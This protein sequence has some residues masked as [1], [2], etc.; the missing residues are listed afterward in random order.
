MLKDGN[1]D[2]Q[3]KKKPARRKVIEEE[4]KEE[5]IFTEE[6]LKQL[7]L[8]REIAAVEQ[9]MIEDKNILEAHRKQ[10][11]LEVYREIKHYMKKKRKR[12]NQM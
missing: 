1:S 11:E 7:R 9:K 4:V 8:E 6:E 2:L 12:Y 3:V 5:D 10:A